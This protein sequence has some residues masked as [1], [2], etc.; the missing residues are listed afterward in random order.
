MSEEKRKQTGAKIQKH[1]AETISK[2]LNIPVFVIDQEIID[3][4][5]EEVKQLPEIEK[6]YSQEELYREVSDFLSKLTVFR[7]KS[8]AE[9][10]ER[11]A[12][13]LTSL[14]TEKNY[15]ATIILP[16]VIGLPIGTKIGHLEIVEQNIDDEKLDEYLQF[17]KKE[18]NVHI[19]GR[20]QGKVLFTAYT[21]TNVT[22]VL[23]KHLE[24]PFAI[25]SLI[26]DFDLDVRDCTGIIKSP[27]IS[28]A[29]FLEPH[30]EIRGWSRYHPDFLAE[31]LDKLS[32]ISLDKKP[33][34]LKQKILQAIQVYGL[35]RLSYKAEIRF[36]FLV[37]SFESLLLTENDRDYLGKKIS[38]KTAFLLEDEYEKRL[39][40]YKLMK[41]FYGKR[42]SLV[43]RGKIEISDSEVR[44]IENLFRALVFKILELSN[45]YTKMEQKSHNK[46][47]EGIEDYINK[48]RFS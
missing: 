43:H 19:D 37:S 21:S 20:S 27:D 22:D 23:Y 40:L 4:L 34:R 3:K 8:E 5:F 7:P 30:N 31:H 15:E 24:L 42:S 45:E 11:F 32:R 33:N 9:I 12:E 29:Y 48:L 13:F 26:L 1:L 41:G 2:N 10:K 16:S 36:L 17:L 38:E 18:K 14:E 6:K 47:K 39:E 35:S 25:L 28:T 46:D 44:T